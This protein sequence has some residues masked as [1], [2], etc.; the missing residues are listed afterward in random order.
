M[1]VVDV[2]VA[3]GRFLRQVVRV[4]FLQKREKRGE[5]GGGQSKP[6]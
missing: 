4:G 2:V 5:K 6:C 1:V 3:E